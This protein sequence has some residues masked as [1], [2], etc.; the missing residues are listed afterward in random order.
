MLFPSK[1]RL[2]EMR[3]SV[4]RSAATVAAGADSMRP[5]GAVEV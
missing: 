2:A 3:E 1:A 5:I 4:S